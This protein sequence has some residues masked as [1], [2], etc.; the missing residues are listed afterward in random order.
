M[1]TD[2]NH[3]QQETSKVKSEVDINTYIDN[4]IIFSKYNNGIL[5]LEVWLNV[6]TI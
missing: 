5:S 4:N 3:N 6:Q 2:G 1:E